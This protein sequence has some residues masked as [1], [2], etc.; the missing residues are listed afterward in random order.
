MKLCRENSVEYIVAPYK[1]DAQIAFLVA[2]D[3]ADFAISEDSDLLVHGCIKVKIQSFL[4]INYTI[5]KYLL[6]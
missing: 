3:H 5:L 6:V 4:N 1:A 2:N